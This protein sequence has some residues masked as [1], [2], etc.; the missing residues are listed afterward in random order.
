MKIELE[1]EDIV[2]RTVRVSGT[3]GRVN[4]P[5]DW[6]GRDVQACLLPEQK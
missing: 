2:K 4:V 3:S 1:V 5:K 6:T